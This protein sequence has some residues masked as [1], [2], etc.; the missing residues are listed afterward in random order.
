M[1]EELGLLYLDSTPVKWEA[2]IKIQEAVIYEETI[3]VTCNKKGQT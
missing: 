2:E 1:E 3:G